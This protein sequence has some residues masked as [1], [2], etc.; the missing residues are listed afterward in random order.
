M[1]A[2]RLKTTSNPLQ[3]RIPRSALVSVIASLVTF[4]LNV[5]LFLANPAHAEDPKTCDVSIR[6]LG[7]KTDAG[8]L[9]VALI[10]SAEAFDANGEPVRDARVAIENGEA[11]ARFGAIPYGSYAVKVFHDENSNDKLDTNLIGYPRESFGFSMDAMG[12]FGP[13]SFEEAKFEV[14]SPKLE[15]TINMH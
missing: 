3:Q 13:P 12:R 2:R 6:I 5:S 4:T 15:L 7:L 10:D 14:S 1:P 11:I 9:I 8:R